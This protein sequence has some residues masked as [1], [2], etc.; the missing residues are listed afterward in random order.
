MINGLIVIPARAGS[1]GIW[2]KNT[3]SVA[4][5]PLIAGALYKMWTLQLDLLNQYETLLHIAVSTNDPEIAARTRLWTQFVTAAHPDDEPLSPIT[6]VWRPDDQAQPD[7]TIDQML[8]YTMGNIEQEGWPAE[9]DWVGVHQLT[10]PTLRQSTMLDMIGKFI[11]DEAVDSMATMVM[12]T[13][14][15]WSNDGPLHK[16][17]RNRQF[18]NDD[19]LQY[20]ETGGLHVVRGYPRTDG[21]FG[22]ECLMIGERHEPYLL[23]HDEGIDLDT[24]QDLAA[25]ELVLEAPKVSI[26]TSGNP[27]MGTGHIR[28]ATALAAALDPYSDPT[29]YFVATSPDMVDLVPERH[30]GG[31]IEPADIPDIWEDSNAVVVDMLDIAADTIDEQARKWPGSAVVL[32]RDADIADHTPVINGLY[33]EERSNLCGPLWVD[34]RDEFRNGAPFVVGPTLQSVLISFGGSD[35]ARLSGVVANAVHKYDPELFITIIDPPFGPIQPGELEPQVE[36]S[37]M[38]RVEQNAEMATEM[39]NH[40][41]LICGRGRTMFE[42]AH[43]GLPSMSFAVNEREYEMHKA[44]KGVFDANLKPGR[45]QPVGVEMAIIE[46]LAH[47]ED[48]DLRHAMS[49]AG[50]QD[51]DGHGIERIRDMVL[52]A[53]KESMRQAD[54]VYE[55]IQEEGE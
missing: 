51:V 53:G 27:V 12:D 48:Q 2:R 25:A 14:L 28:R 11:D 49:V 15:R 4:G 7:Q 17:R 19:D 38:V 33:D 8:T 6:T 55:I 9:F 40:D 43:M 5:V 29:I 1:I 50:Q 39:W 44:P 26:F 32:E 30:N 13:G 10:S 41:F 36:L 18:A 54:H 45:F 52:A 23:P 42:A 22:S 37:A 47:F 24:P 3:R 16:T 31:R 34:I 21:W 35:P 46:T 20:Q